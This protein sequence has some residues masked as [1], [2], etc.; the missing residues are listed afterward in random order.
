MLVLILILPPFSSSANEND[1]KEGKPFLTGKALAKQ[2][3][4]AKMS[5]NVM[6][7]LAE[8][9]GIGSI[10]G[11]GAPA[12]ASLRYSSFLKV[13]KFRKGDKSAPLNPK[14]KGGK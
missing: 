7:N 3:I 14:L 10:M 2:E 9:H 6:L 1:N 4:I 8:Q 13:F 11:K 5:G 12:S